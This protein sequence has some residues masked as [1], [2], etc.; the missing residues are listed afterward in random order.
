MSERARDSQGFEG[1]AGQIMDVRRQALVQSCAPHIWN[2][3]RDDAKKL[4]FTRA[5]ELPGD[6][7]QMTLDAIRGRELS[8]GADEA[9]VVDWYLDAAQDK[10]ADSYAR[11]PDLRQ[12]IKLQGIYPKLTQVYSPAELSVR[13]GQVTMGELKSDATV[14]VPARLAAFTNLCAA[15]DSLQSAV[16]ERTAKDAG[17]VFKTPG[18]LAMNAIAEHLRGAEEQPPLPGHYL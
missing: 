11:E 16:V 15:F 6:A 2:F 8:L 13:L 9:E 17:M 14:L 7:S 4:Y 12:L 18:L 3:V 1:Q 5:S 10:I